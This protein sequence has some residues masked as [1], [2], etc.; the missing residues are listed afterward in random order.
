MMAAVPAFPKRIIMNRRG[1]IIGE[2]FLIVIGVLVALAVETALDE[3]QDDSLRDEYLARIAADVA[4]DKL[5]IEYRI[6]FFTAVTQFS[7]DTFDWMQSDSPMNKDALLA[8]FYAAEVWPFVPNAS[9]YEDL[10]STGNIRLLRNIEL[11][12]NLVRFHIQADASR[13]GWT[14][15]EKYREIIRGV[16]PTDVQAQIRENCP[17]TDNVDQRP[18]GFPP[19]ELHDIDYD[20][21]TTLFEPLRSD[22]DFLRTLTYRNSELAVVVRLLRQQ[23]TVA[24]DVLAEIDG[25]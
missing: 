16:I 23:A 18:S 21:L 15:E 2:F 11:R 24:G 12:T 9:T 8:S 25:Q 4:A 19:C 5:S 6:E 3:R 1:R 20:A 17:T 10:M 22:V 14:P 13:P 7:Q